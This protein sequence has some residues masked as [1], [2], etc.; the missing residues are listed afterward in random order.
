MKVLSDGGEH[1]ARDINERTGRNDAR[2]SV[3]ELVAMGVMIHKRTVPGTRVK[4]YRLKS[5]NK[6]YFQAEMFGADGLTS[7]CA[8]R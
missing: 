7:L 2:K 8:R 3:S 4:C 6:A 1:T 5:K